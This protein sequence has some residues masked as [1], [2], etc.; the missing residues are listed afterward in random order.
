MSGTPIL[1][2]V[3]VDDP[4]GLA[5]AIEG[6]AD[7]IE[8]CAALSVGGLTP[9]L[10]L[11]IAAAETG[12]PVMAM[13][14]PREGG[15][16]VSAEER[17]VMLRDIE[18]ARDA[19]LAGVVFG[20]SLPDGR[21]DRDTL[22]ILRDAAG[23]LDVTLHRAFDLVPDAEAALETAI[24]IGIPR[25]LTSG[26]TPSVMDGLPR[27]ADLVRAAN[28]RLVIMPGA[29]VTP[30]NAAEIAKATGASEI[31]TSGGE[32]VTNTDPAL[33]RFGFAPERIK[34][35]SATRIAATRAALNEM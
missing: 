1:L 19:G 34:R 22:A 29:G 20:A 18:A 14:R 21:L 6:G 10:G 15:F 8:L 5:A 12:V 11:M 27:I 32:T 3:C 31:H 30:D 35:T 9:T 16:A 26:Q 4:T 25:I 7:R 23:D 28:G 33:A 17:G 2:E 24:E 13:I